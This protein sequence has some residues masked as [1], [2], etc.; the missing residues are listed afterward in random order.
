M[1]YAREKQT[2]VETDTE[3]SKKSPVKEKINGLEGLDDHARM[4]FKVVNYCNSEIVSL[5]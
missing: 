1:L 3:N 2:Q 5:Y 4:C